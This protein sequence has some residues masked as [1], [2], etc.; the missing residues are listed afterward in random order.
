MIKTEIMSNCLCMKNLMNFQKSSGPIMIWY[1][2][3]K[4]CK[5]F[6]FEWH[7]ILFVYIFF[8]RPEPFFFVVKNGLFLLAIP[9]LAK[10]C[11]QLIVWYLD[12]I[13]LLSEHIIIH[14]YIKCPQILQVKTLLQPYTALTCRVYNEM[15]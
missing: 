8:P 10:Y 11:T 4:K 7:R 14:C 2:Y 1:I 13:F 15:I 6:G 12:L 9:Y 5:A 3:W